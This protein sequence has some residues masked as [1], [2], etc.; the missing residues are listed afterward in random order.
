MK[1]SFLSYNL[2]HFRQCV[3]S[4]HF[5]SIPSLSYFLSPFMLFCMVILICQLS[6]YCSGCLHSLNLSSPF[7]FYY[8]L[9]HCSSLFQLFPFYSNQPFFYPPVTLLSDSLN[10]SFSPS[11]FLKYMI[12]IVFLD[13]RTSRRVA[14][15][16]DETIKKL[17][18]VLW[19]EKDKFK[20]FSL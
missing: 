13:C 11:P 3:I 6:F 9:R 5:I 14:H 17:A 15:K 16:F 20:L 4:F 7:S 18:K 12:Q 1:A 10:Q 8:S 2:F 19:L